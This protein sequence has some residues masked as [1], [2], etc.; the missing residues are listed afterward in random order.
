MSNRDSVTFGDISAK[1]FGNVLKKVLK[2]KRF[3]QKS[4][5][6]ALSRAWKEV[7][8]EEIADETKIVSYKNGRLRVEVNSSVLLQE[9]SGFMKDN[10]LEELQQTSGGTDVSDLRFCLGSDRQE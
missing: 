2:K 10:I 6:G 5:Y 4:K 7:V 3:Y 9:L 8:G 1:E